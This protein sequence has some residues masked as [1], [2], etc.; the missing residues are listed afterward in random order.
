MR[1]QGGGKPAN[2]LA[3]RLDDAFGSVEGF[4]RRF[5]DTAN[6]LFGSGWTWLVMDAEERL[7]VQGTAN[8]ENPLSKDYVPL[9]VL[10]VWEHAYYL[11]YCSDR[12][13]Y[14]NAF[15]DHLLSWDFVTENIEAGRARSGNVV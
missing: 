6:G 2:A 13:G 10:D 3:R 1:P 15:L 5:A 8:A 4:R 14:V 7:Y 12:E 11:D 9:L